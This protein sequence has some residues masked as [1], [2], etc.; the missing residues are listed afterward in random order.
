MRL[1]LLGILALLASPLRAAD[2]D[3]KAADTAIEKAREFFKVPGVAVAVVRGNDVIYAKGFGTRSTS[4][5]DEITPDTLFAIG[6]C[7]KA[8][9]A[10]AVAA[11]VA[12]GKMVWDAPVKNYVPGFR[13]ADPAADRDVS[14]RD[15]LS[16]RTGLPRH[17]LLWQHPD[18]SR[19]EL[20]RRCAS[21]PAS[22]GFRAEYQ[23][24]NLMYVAAGLAVEKA[25]GRA[26]EAY[27]R[28]KF[29]VPL[30]MSNTN[31]RVEETK[32]AANHAKP[33]LLAD[34]KLEEIPFFNLDA[35]CP[36]GGINSSAND[37][38][39]WLK[40][41]LGNGK[42]DDKTLLPKKQLG[43]MHTGYSVVVPLPIR[44][45]TEEYT[46]Q[47]TYG[48]GW[49]IAD[50]RGHKIVHH[51]GSIDG[52]TSFILLAPR[53][54]LGIV[55]LNNRH[56]ATLPL[57][58][59]YTLLDQMLGLPAVDWNAKHKAAQVGN[60]QLWDAE[61]ALRKA[62]RRPGT[63]TS[64]PLVEYEGNYEHPGYG[65]ISF[66]AEGDR[67]VMKFANHTERFEHFH[68]DTF[69]IP[70]QTGVWPYMW[71]DGQATFR[72]SAEGEVTAVQ[73]LG[74]EFARKK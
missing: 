23:Y 3:E 72:V 48:L 45:V 36:A 18:W 22:K 67:F 34:G 26:W 54:K 32:K 58:V 65:K 33:Y 31:F 39:K 28:E 60:E 9:T 47:S 21:L 59:G 6:S 20:V 37:L 14:V 29:L 27:V 66:R 49:T 38:A 74:V 43:E 1:A 5:K 8:F 10:A 15:L 63:L 70:K 17:D 2:F 57:A 12:D 35:M 7:S 40:F 41:Q 11:L 25:A 68:F 44:A 69:H 24:N 64:L 46:V 62:K 4:G 56:R 55:V 50:Y 51:G 13:L 52:F 61:D 42:L 73:F 16:H 30:G 53:E 19:E 71:M